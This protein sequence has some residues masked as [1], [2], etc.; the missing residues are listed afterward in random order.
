MS[1]RITALTLLLSA[2]LLLPLVVADDAKKNDKADDQTDR[3]AA[4]K[5][6]LTPLGVFVGGWKGSGMRK[7]GDTDGWLAEAE[8]AWSFDGGRA[9][10]VFEAEESKFYKTGRF[11]PGKKEGTFTFT[12]TLPD[13]KTTESFT[14]KL[15]DGD[16]LIMDA[17]KDYGD[18]RPARV[19]VRTVARGKRL[20]VQLY[21]SNRA[22][23]YTQIALIGYTRKGS[24]FA[25]SGVQNEC[26]VTGGE[27]GRQVT[28]NG[29]TYYVCCKGCLQAFEENPAKI[30]AEYKARKEEEKKAKER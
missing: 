16:R 12:G 1:H 3:V 30:I 20:I 18:G 4:D 9:A 10:I 11:L 24:N 22:D 19:S 17:D 2:A 6:A 13:G 7:L 27:A 21:E 5:K 15:D 25:S 23:D 8:W 28:Y 26:V 29:E 14:G